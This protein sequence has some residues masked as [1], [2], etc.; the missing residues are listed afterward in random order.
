VNNLGGRVAVVTGVSRKNG[1]GFAIARRL[2]SMGADLLVHSFAPYDR[3]FPS[4]SEVGD[5]AD[6]AKD[7]ASYGTRIAYLEA[8]FSDP[9]SPAHLMK[10]AVER[11]GH[12]DI[13]VINHTHDTLKTLDELTAEEIDRHMSVNV[14][15]ALLL[16]QAFAMQHDGRPGGRIIL[17]TSGQHLGQMP[18]MA[19]VASKG[20]LHQLTNSLSAYFIEKGVTVNTVNPGPT[21]TYNPDAELDKAV[22]ERMPQG[23]WGEPDDA[24][25]L[26]GWLV[27]DDAVWITGQL[28]NSEGGFRRG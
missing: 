11:L 23:R 22:L 13:L 16:V 21:K 4:V 3:Q 25:R 8:D 15:A 20:A 12:V 2:A 24:A 18:H 6:L 1:I 28:I 7:L 19:Y 14:R 10:S 26:I 27:S 9:Q 17:L 5:P